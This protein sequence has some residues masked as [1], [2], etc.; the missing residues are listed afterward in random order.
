MGIE[1]KEPLLVKQVEQLA[2]ETTRP[3][4]EVLE[5]AAWEY[6]EAQE[7]QAIHDETEAFWAQHEELVAAYSGQYVALYKGQVVGHDQ[8]VVALERRLR[9]RFGLLPI[10]IAHVKREQRRDL[11][12]R[13]GRLDSGGYPDDSVSL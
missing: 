2:A 1:L 10:L 4:E 7:R 3:P 5:R 6:L 11:L 12:W 8:D 9:E 13:G